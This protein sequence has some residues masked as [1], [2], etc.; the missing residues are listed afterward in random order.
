[1]ATSG[2]QLRLLAIAI[3]CS[4]WA[5]QVE[6]KA[7]GAFPSR[8]VISKWA[9]L[10]Q[11]RIQVDLDKFTGIKKL[12]KT[13]DDL[14]RAKM[15][16]ID[17]H[18]LVHKMSRDIT[19]NLEKKMEALEKLVNTAEETVKAFKFD[20]SIKMADVSNFVKMRDF[21]D[22]DPR[23]VY[24]N[25]FKKDV[26][27]S[28][29]GVHIPVEIYEQ[30]PQILNGLKWS[31]ALDEI[32]KNNSKTYPDLMWQHF[33]STSGFMRSYPASKWV[34]LPR[35]PNFPDLYDVRL[36]PWYVH[37]SSSPKDMLILMD[38]S[39]SM[40]G[41]TMEI[42][43][44]AVKTLLT[45]LGENDFVNI[46]S[47]NTTA[48]WVS[49]FDTLVQANRR[50]KQILSKKIE[51]LED[52]NMAKLSLGLEFAFKALARFRENRTEYWAGSECNQVIMLFSDGGTEEAWDVLEKYNSDKSIRVF[53]YAIGPHPIPY[54]TLKEI[55]CS[56]RGYFTAIQAMGAIRTKIQDYI[57][58]LGRPMVSS[59]ARNFEWTNF[60]FDSNGLG[61]M[62][63][64]TLPVF[65]RTEIG[66]HTFVG[67]MGID[68]ALQ[69]LSDYEPFYE[70]G[71]AG[72]SFGINHNGFVVFHP[73]LKT[74]FEFLDDPPHLDFLDTEIE[75]SAKEELREAMIN[76]ETSK[77]SLTSLLKMP[78]G[79]YIVRHRMEYF[80]TP[81]NKTTF[82]IAIAMPTDRT[83]YLR[84]D[85]IDVPKGFDLNKNEIKGIHLAPWKY[86]QGKILNLRTSELLKNLSYSA[87]TD[88]SSC[89]LH[90]LQRLVWDIHKTTDIVHY[91]HAQNQEGERK[92][93]VATFI[94]SEGGLTRVFPPSESHH[95]EGQLNPSK[96]MVF[97]RAYYG[98]DYVLLPPE[99]SY[100]ASANES[101]AVVTVVK[102]ISFTKNGVTF[103]PAIVGVMVDPL[104]LQ[105]Y[106]LSTPTGPGKV[107]IS[108]SDVDDIVCYIIDDGGFIITTNQP[109]LF[110]VMGKFL[111]TV[112]SEI[113]TELYEK[114]IYVRNEDINYEDRCRKD[115][116]ISA[117]FKVSPLPFH[118]TITALKIGWLFDFSAWSQ[119]KYW[120]LSLF[121]FL[122]LPQSEALPEFYELANETTCNTHEAQYYWGR[123]GRS[124]SGE[125]LC[126]N[127]TR[128]Y[129]LAKIGQL[130]TLLLVTEKPC[131]PIFCDYVPPLLQ[132]KEEITT[133]E[134][135]PCDRPLRYR[136]RP[137]KCYDFSPD[138]NIN[139]CD[140]VGTL[141]LPHVALIVELL[142]L[143]FVTKLIH[144]DYVVPFALL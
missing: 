14:R 84:M 132:E 42:M 76:L 40:H 133:P 118:S 51:D 129:S 68:V 47:F 67:V 130:N 36:R 65:N 71:P 7:Y 10:F 115:I 119:I 18:S 80:Y 44:I 144:V 105:P 70:I 90:L 103:K 43:K 45:T 113:M 108:C 126:S 48:K 79:K 82:S 124:H 53:S 20:Q 66:N 54:A 136:R 23:L 85:D 121:S 59:V 92:G 99:T 8:E 4:F 96:S 122:N 139:E 9:E 57:R 128:H 141:A 87:R 93:V 106:L 19:K 26:N 29:S 64:V 15:H 83:Q 116:K 143:M 73:G 31:S 22:N 94:Q 25:K 33:G 86:C 61:M 16:K 52:G 109:D 11:N 77:R 2:V 55:A 101:E 34:V 97:Q 114:K 78:N 134:T 89:K 3:L 88:P 39:G 125:I 91:W 5:F 28:Y 102:A 50:N 120:V 72:Y 69:E 30:S 6:P 62:T 56:N 112:D 27:F 111:G 24:S 63:T 110:A 140:A 12:E 35:K 127:C 17:G 98:D 37:A 74:D 123:W 32:F 46:I 137:D 131:A 107:P 104:W 95:L 100:D 41:Q 38:V 21:E 75:N 142:C 1:M 138:E 60:Y 135:S 49:C 13:Y 58:V 117:G 81:V